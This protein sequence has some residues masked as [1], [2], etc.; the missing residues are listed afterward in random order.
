MRES[1]EREGNRGTFHAT[2]CVS[3]F[4]ASIAASLLAVVGFE[5]ICTEAGSW[6]AWSAPGDPSETP[7]T[8]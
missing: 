6:R 3:D 2:Y 7:T 1:D 5:N 4:C 8:K